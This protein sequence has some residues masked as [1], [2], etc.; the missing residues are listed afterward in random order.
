MTATLHDNASKLYLAHR[1]GMTMLPRYGLDGAT[2]D[3]AQ[4]L[5]WTFAITFMS[6][7]IP[8]LMNMMFGK[9]IRSVSTKAYP[10]IPASWGLSIRK[11]V[12]PRAVELSNGRTLEDV[13]TSIYC[14]GY[15]F[16][17]PFLSEDFNPC[18]VIGEVPNLYRGVV[19]LHPD[20]KIR[21]SLAFLGQTAVPLPAPLQM[22]RQAMAVSQ[23]WR[24]LSPIPL[25]NEMKHWH[26]GWLKW[27]KDLVAKQKI[28]SHF[29]TAFVPLGGHLV[30]LDKTAGT[31]LFDNFGW[32]K[33]RAWSFWWS[34][35]ELYQLCKN[36]LFTPVVC[37]LLIWTYLNPS[38][39]PEIFFSTT[40]TTFTHSSPHSQSS[41]HSPQPQLTHTLKTKF[42]LTFNMKFSIVAVMAV[43]V[44]VVSA[45][46]TKESRSQCDPGS[47]SCDSPTGYG[48]DYTVC[49]SRHG[50][51]H[52]SCQEG[53]ACCEVQNGIACA[54]PGTCREM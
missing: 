37:R 38:P 7:W 39:L 28:K 45:V 35:Q 10:N 32:L 4:T 19:P 17:V 49:D 20:S 43:I 18:P 36:G 12:G 15:N 48:R 42:Q 14:T 8:T 40:L 54:T 22:E 47:S 9:V 34:D 13:D 3:Q 24:G 30:W 41:T 2:F 25:A 23:V 52:F 46:P 27:R 21:E 26:E 11:V 33:H 50:L 5:S 6:I 51:H 1:T 29:Y 53:S 44:A 31:G 16:A